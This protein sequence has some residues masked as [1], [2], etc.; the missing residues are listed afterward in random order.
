MSSDP[1]VGELLAVL[2]AAAPP[3]ARILEL[4]TGTGVSLGWI[5]HGLGRR[6]DATVLSV[7]TDET[8]LDST[9]SAPWPS[10]VEFVCSDGSQVV[11]DGGPFDLIFA[12]A[13]GGKID[14]LEATITALAPRGVLLVDD[15]NPDLHATDGL[16]IPLQRVRDTLVSH[17][18]LVATEMPYSTHVIL[19]VKR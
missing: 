15:M 14:S 18:E 16:M 3:G 11:H 1:P 4:G 17:H 12:D 7:D 6:D 19:A 5:V 2:A 10:W 8:L 13:P 9:R